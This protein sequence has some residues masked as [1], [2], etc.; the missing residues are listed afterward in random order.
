MSGSRRSRPPDPASKR[1][2]VAAPALTGPAFFPLAFAAPS[3]ILKANGEEVRPILKSS[4][5]AGGVPVHEVSRHTTYRRKPRFDDTP[6]VHNYA[7]VSPNTRYPESW[8]LWPEWI[9]MPYLDAD[10][11]RNLLAYA[12][13]RERA[14]NLAREVDE[15]VG[16]KGVSAKRGSRDY[17]DDRR[18]VV[19]W[20]P[21][22]GLMYTD[23]LSA[24]DRE[25]LPSGILSG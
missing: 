5:S 2:L 11:S 19:A 14:L 16:V 20:T 23:P 6:V 7:E 12:E 1:C 8:K 18:R 17:G 10:P 13:C 9:H 25:E 22:G 15:D 24:S 21:D 4:C 3:V